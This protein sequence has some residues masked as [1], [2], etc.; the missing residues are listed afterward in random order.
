MRTCDQLLA[1][2]SYEMYVVHC[3]PGFDLVC[4]RKCLNVFRPKIV[5]RKVFVF[6]REKITSRAQS[7]R[8]SFLA[9]NFS[10][11]RTAL[12]DSVI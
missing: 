11:L 1:E 10:R 9:R 12:F 5:E 3:T 6:E 8:R 2:K 7:S 4:L